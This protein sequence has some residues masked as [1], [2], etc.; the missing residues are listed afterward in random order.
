MTKLILKCGICLLACLVTAIIILTRC[1]HYGFATCVAYLLRTCNTCWE[2]QG[3]H[4]ALLLRR[5]DS[6]DVEVVDDGFRAQGLDKEAWQEIQYLAHASEEHH[7]GNRGHE[8]RHVM[9]R[10]NIEKKLH[11]ERVRN[12]P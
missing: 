1:G 6:L 8:L 12:A 11:Y 10:D 7:R 9:E 3:P 5:L 2:C 4:D